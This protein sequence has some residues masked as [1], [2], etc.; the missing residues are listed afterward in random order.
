MMKKLISLFMAA[1]LLA[2]LLPAV[3]AEAPGISMLRINPYGGDEAAI[4]TV[5]WFASS[6]KYF[7]FLP[8]DVDLTAAKVYF[9]ASGGVTLDGA[10]I[11]SG[12]SAAAFAEGAHTLSCG[13][14][15]YPLTVC[16]SADIPAVFITTESGSLAY[17]HANKENREPGHIRVYENG[18]QTLDKDLKQIKGRGNATWESPKKPYNIK[19]DKKTEVL[20]MAKAKKW[21]L[22]ANYAD[23]S[24]IHNDYGWE[25]ADAFGLPYSSEYRHIDLYINGDYMGSYVICESVEIG[26]NRIDIT[27]L[28]KANETA[29]PDVKIEELP[30]RGTGANGAVEDGSVKGSR[31]WADIPNDPEDVTGGYLL[32]FEMDYRYINEPCGFVTWNGQPIV[33]KSPE[34][35]S[36]AEVNYIADYMDAGTKALYSATGF[37]DEGKHYS[38]YFDVESLVNMYLLQELSMNHDVAV[39]SFFA[40]KPAGDSKVVFAPVWDM[41]NAFGFRG[42][43]LGVN[44]SQPDLWWANQRGRYSILTVL[45]AAYQQEAFRAAVRERWAE[46]RQTDIFETVDAR[47][48]AQADAIGASAAM[49]GVR[50]NRFGTTDLAAARDG[51][52]AEVQHSVR[53]VGN[54]SAALDTG[55]SAESAYLHYELNGGMSG[56]FA[57]STPIRRIGESVT[58]RE[59]TG[60]GTIEAP[61]G[62]AFSGWNTKAD[63]TGTDYQPGDTLTLTEEYTVLY[64]Q[65][66]NQAP[67]NGSKP[68][69]WQRIVDF[70]HRIGDFFRRIFGIA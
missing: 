57:L 22:L 55:F 63:G 53:F 61:A 50:W 15:T 52:R 19:F 51:W 11:A 42:E 25:F 43:N 6:G 66:N 59:I 60:N 44:L 34:Y 68:S 12:D 8:A 2:S 54:R 24:Q 10:A 64:A 5:S 65:W 30:L 18:A 48:A 39:S 40:Y 1:L 26:E 23:R 47:I 56:K 7:L 46:L 9:T 33:V 45:S 28:E 35:A 37:N 21:T 14:K 69:F 67:E 16:F 17:I 3:F 13:G 41:D 36:E 49:D 20:G 62:R 70:F 31:K 4:D 27:D 58:V 38:E 29:N 32:E